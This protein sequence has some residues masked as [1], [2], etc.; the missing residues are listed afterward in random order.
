MREKNINRLPPTHTGT[1]A[2][3]G[4]QNLGICSDQ[5]PNSQPFLLY[6][7]ILQSTEPLARDN[8]MF[9]V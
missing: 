9:D 1:W 2:R 8:V 5:E 3:D 6:G 7:T 4:T